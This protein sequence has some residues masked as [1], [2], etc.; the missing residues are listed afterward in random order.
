MPEDGSI[1]SISI[2]HEGGS[3]DMLLAVYSDVND[4]PGQRLA[5]TEETSIHSYQGWQTVK[6]TTAV[7]VNEGDTIWLA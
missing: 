6:L 7:D 5:I 3:G 2:Y 4:L 1:Q